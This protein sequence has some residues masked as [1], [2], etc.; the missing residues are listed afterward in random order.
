MGAFDSCGFYLCLATLLRETKTMTAPDKT[1]AKATAQTGGFNEYGALKRVAICSAEVA[2]ENQ[3]T[4]DTTWESALFLDRPNY[5]AAVKEHAELIEI[6]SSRGAKVDVLPQCPGTGLNLIYTRDSSII[7]P[8]GIIIGKLTN[9]ARQPESDAVAKIYQDMGLPIAG[10]ITG[11][12]LLEGG[13]FIWLDEKTC[14]VA[15]GCRTNAAGIR[16]LKAL[17]GPDVHVEVVGLP[18]WE[19]PSICVHLMSFISPVA[20]DLA[21]VY[22]RLMPVPFREFLLERGIKFIEVPDEEYDPS[23]GCNV[24]AIAPGVCVVVDG[25]PETRRRIE[26]A[27]CE[28]IAYQG[29]EISMKGGGGPTCLTRPLLRA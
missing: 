3:T 12:G 23:M 25:N 16:Q 2:F 28:V 15:H 18:Y 5:S 8:N 11:T 21:V 20:Q 4:C 19:G 1:I 17:L 10:R 29:H 6:L 13:D 9:T 27:G 22:P 26:S 14:A 7:A 24:L